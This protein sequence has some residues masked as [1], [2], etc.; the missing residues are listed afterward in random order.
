MSGKTVTCALRG[1]AREEQKTNKQ[2]RP[3]ARLTHQ[4]VTQSRLLCSARAGIPFPTAAESSRRRQPRAPI[5]TEPFTTHVCVI[6]PSYRLRRFFVRLRARLCLGDEGISNPA[7]VG[8]GYRRNS[9]C[10]ANLPWGY[11]GRC[12]C[13]CARVCSLA[14]RDGM[15]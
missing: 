12:S 2:P 15:E 10:C 11:G 3:K 8:C 1:G 9:S 7:F 4:T 6:S 14:P 5:T 13:V